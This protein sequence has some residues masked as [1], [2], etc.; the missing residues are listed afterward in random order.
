MTS[1]PRQVLIVDDEELARLRI[2]RYLEA[3]RPDWTIREAKDGV[4][5]LQ[6]IRDQAPDLVF[7]DIEMPGLDGFDLLR[8]LDER[9]FAVIFQTAFDQFAIKAFDENAVDYLLKPFTDERLERALAKAKVDP[10]PKISDALQEAGRYL[11]R[12]VVTAGARTRVIAAEEVLYFFSE[13]HVT[14]IMMDGI[15]FAYDQSLTHLEQHL[16]PK[17][18]IRIH[19]NSIIALRAVA[20]VERGANAK[21]KL[22]S[23]QT[24]AV[25]RERKVPLLDALTATGLAATDE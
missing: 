11:E 5:G 18:F 9:P 7:L 4:D 14:R 8:Q 2:R 22:K 25:S 16:D 1:D 17:Q 12:F 23:G 20:H 19:R 6:A 24:L 21:V 10:L 3:K 13:S 15:D